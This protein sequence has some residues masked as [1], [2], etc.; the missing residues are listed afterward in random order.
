MKRRDFLNTSALGAG[1]FAIT[2]CSDSPKKA[3]ALD[4]LNNMTEDIE[5]ISI[6]EYRERVSKAQG[7]MKMTGISALILDAGSS[8]T[9]FTGITWWPSERPMLA[10]I[11]VEG[12]VRYVCPAFEEDRLEEKKTT[13]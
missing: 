9:Y 2:G 1:A 4:T 3:S 8:M 6:E 12:T 13:F 11:P 5:P 10:I 7:L